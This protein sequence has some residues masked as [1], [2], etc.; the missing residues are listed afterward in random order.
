MTWEELI[1][2]L[3]DTNIDL[4]NEF[5]NNKYTDISKKKTQ[6]EFETIGITPDILFVQAIDGLIRNH[7]DNKIF[8]NVNIL[9]FATNPLESIV[10]R[11]LYE[12]MEDIKKEFISLF[13]TEDELIDFFRK[14]KL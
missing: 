9:D 7:I 5:K 14:N 13:K 2:K 11:K 12:N 10:Y 6:K 4:T 3:K 8:K 1:E